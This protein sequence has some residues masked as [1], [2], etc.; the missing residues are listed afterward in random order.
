LKPDWDLKDSLD[1]L[2]WGLLPGVVAKLGIT[3]SYA[4]AQR[5]IAGTLSRQTRDTLNALYWLL[6]P[7]RDAINRSIRDEYFR[8]GDGAGLTQVII[9]AFKQ[10]SQTLQ[11]AYAMAAVAEEYQA[12]LPLEVLVSALGV[13]YSDWLD[14]VPPDAPAWGLLYPSGG[15]DDPTIFYS[16][17][18]AIVTRIVIEA[19]N[20]GTLSRS[21]ELRI[22]MRLLQGCTGTQGVYREFVM[23]VL[24]PYKR[25]MNRASYEEGRT[26]YETAEH[27]LPCSD[28]TLLHHKALWTKS[29]GHDP[30]AAIEELESALRATPFPYSDRDEANEHIHTSLAAATI[31]A[32][33]QRLIPPDEAQQRVLSELAQARSA[34]FFN[35]HAVHVEATLILR[36]RRALGDTQV[37]DQLSMTAG[38]LSNIDRTLLLLEAHASRGAVSWAKDVEMLSQARNDL[39]VTD[40][41]DDELARV[42][43]QLW[44]E[45]G[46][47]EGFV[48]VARRL[49]GVARE[50]NRGS[51][52]NLAFDY[53]RERLAWIE[54]RR[55]SPTAQFRDA[56]LHIYYAWRVRRDVEAAPLAERVDWAWMLATVEAIMQD[57]ELGKNPFYSYL[58]ALALCHLN[59][60]SAGHAIFAELRRQSVA[61]L[62]T[63]RD[64][65]MTEEGQPRV[66]QGELKSGTDGR[67]YCYAADLHQDFV[68]RRGDEWPSAGEIVHVRV[69]F[70][71][72]G[73]M[74]IR[75]KS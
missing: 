10:S 26:L 45:Y 43:D 33:E 64:Y 50:S 59:N 35:P 24:V 53:C 56:T 39:L 74:A 30:L 65:L 22:L 67:M 72:A 52:Y 38:A 17:R 62:W 12:P 14:T 19:I 18:N 57:I 20:G 47:Q 44:E 7:T 27:A 51:D 15:D 21:G 23:R 31:D 1:D 69:M 5:Y 9:G 29:A 66:V 61:D 41:D 48:V 2:E 3:Q 55:A 42:A 49:F 8:L 73:P 71:F 68:T 63:L 60:W 75:P 70:A 37:A 25:L 11:D 28:K 13:S 40:M 54:G 34:R 58:R 16:T 4:E 6:P 46:R 36:L 32:L